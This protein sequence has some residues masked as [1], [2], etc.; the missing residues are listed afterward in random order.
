[1]KLSRRSR[2]FALIAFVIALLAIFAI[3]FFRAAT[4]TEPRPDSSSSAASEPAADAA[5]RQGGR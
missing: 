2:R 5:G 1:M 4:H 3:G